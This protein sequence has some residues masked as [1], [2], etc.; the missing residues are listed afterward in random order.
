MVDHAQQF[1]SA[2]WT[3]QIIGGGR[4]QRSDQRATVDRKGGCL[5]GIGDWDGN[6]NERQPTA[7]IA[8]ARASR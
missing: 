2:A 3:A 4:G 8:A 6:Q 5:L 1:F 7:A